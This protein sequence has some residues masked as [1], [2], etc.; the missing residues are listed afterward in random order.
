VPL[1]LVSVA[2]PAGKGPR[3]VAELLST[4]VLLLCAA[5]IEVNETFANWQSLWLCAILLALAFTLTRV[6]AAQS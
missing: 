1:L 4:G 6:R 5:F 3:G 2:A